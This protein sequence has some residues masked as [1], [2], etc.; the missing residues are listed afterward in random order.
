MAETDL[1]RDLMV[2]LIE[3]LR[4]WFAGEPMIYISGNLLLYYIP[5]NKRKHL[6]PDVF[7]VKGVA[8]RRRDNYLLWQEG[9]G[10]DFVI[11]LTSSSTRKED[12]DKKFKLY[13]DILKVRE[14]FLFDPYGDY[15]DPP[16]QGYRLHKGAYR[17]IRPV[18]GRLPS[19]VLDL[20]LEQHGSNLKLY[21]PATAQWLLAPNEKAEQEALARQQA[22]QEREQE[23][24]ARRQAEAEVERLR[25]EI[26]ALR[27]GPTQQP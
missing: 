16:L 13:R 6:A 7:V 4:A 5:G 12:I 11:E 21:D 19:K 18:R 2:A 1:H 26:E 20:H 27:R 23:T 15:L 10:P 25:R 22:E 9:K 14:Y 24:L 3:I 17:P 8:K